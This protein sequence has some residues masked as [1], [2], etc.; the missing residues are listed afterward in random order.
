MSHRS[1]ETARSAASVPR[2]RAEQRRAR[3][4]GDVVAVVVSGDH[5]VNIVLAGA[6]IA[7]DAGKPLDLVMF[8]D[9]DRSLRSSMVMIDHALTVARTA[10]P[11]LEVMVDLGLSDARG[12]ER[13]VSGQ[14]SQV[15]VGSSVA[16][17]WETRPE[18]LPVTVVDEEG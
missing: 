13:L 1:E 5:C 9:P 7:S 2:Q 6:K 14:I 11:R 17:E 10:F 12:W 3:H 4:R 15:V 16:L 18:E 8:T